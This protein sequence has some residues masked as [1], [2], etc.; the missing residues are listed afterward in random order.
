MNR[1]N[2]RFRKASH[3]PRSK[4][5]RHN[6]RQNANLSSPQFEVVRHDLEVLRLFF[7]PDTFRASRNCINAQS[8]LASFGFLEQ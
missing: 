2:V 3:P 4:H 7:A 5:A 1:H 6:Q 8:P